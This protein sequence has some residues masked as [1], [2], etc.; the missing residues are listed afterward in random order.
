MAI[1]S[2]TLAELLA[3]DAPPSDAMKTAV[4]ASQRTHL[5][6]KGNNLAESLVVNPEC[7]VSQLGASRWFSRVGML[8]FDLHRDGVDTSNLL[9]NIADSYA[10]RWCRRSQKGKNQWLTPIWILL[11]GG[12]TLLVLLMLFLP[13]FFMMQSLAS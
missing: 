13:L 12:M 10:V 4:L 8:A 1:W 5:L 3:M 11:L 9:R 6:S 2:G 7:S